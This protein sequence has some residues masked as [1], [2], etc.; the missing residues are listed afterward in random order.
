MGD[1]DSGRIGR[2]RVS[3]V[4]G[5]LFRQVFL[6]RLFGSLEGQ[7]FSDFEIIVIEQR[8]EDGIRRLVAR[9][10]GLNVTVTSSDRGLSRARNVGLREA[11]GEIIGFPD[12]DCWYSPGTISRVVRRFDFDPSLDV[13]CGRV[14]TGTGPMLNYPRGPVRIDRSNVWHTVVSPGLFVRRSAV[15]AIGDF[16]ELLGVGSGTQ[17]GSGEE[18]DYVLRALTQGRRAEFDPLVHV[19]HPSPEE[20]S[21]R[22]SPAVG[23]SYGFGM[24]RV[25]RDHDYSLSARMK[26]VG[27]PI[28][29]AAVAA[30]RGDAPL[31]QFRVAVARGR[32]RGLT[33]GL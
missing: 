3:L 23:L 26:A 25:L 14:L 31:A 7:R 12:D 28:A 4:T 6:E 17:A 10:P 13:L 30:V 22:L 11:R 33:R 20:V 19:N 21:N 15:D 1:I 9:F 24:G 16:D 32:F 2:P 8:D 5:S 27:R 29:G 18:T